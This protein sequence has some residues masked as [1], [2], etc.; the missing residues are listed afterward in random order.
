MLDTNVRHAPVDPTVRRA[1]ILLGCPMS[2]SAESCQGRSS[3]EALHLDNPRRLR[4]PQPGRGQGRVVEVRGAAPDGAARLQT[5]PKEQREPLEQ[6]VVALT[7]DTTWVGSSRGVSDAQ[8]RARF[9]RVGFSVGIAPPG[10]G[11]GAYEPFAVPWF[12]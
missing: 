12:A 3:R 1:G 9:A 8:A 10:T 11:K 7:S 2:A 6:P 4:D 5:S